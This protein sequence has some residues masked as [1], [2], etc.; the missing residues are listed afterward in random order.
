[1]T[2]INGRQDPSLTALVVNCTPLLY[3]AGPDERFDRP[4]H[5]R[6]ASSL[7]AV[8]DYLTVIQDDAN[9][10]AW[11]DPTLVH[12]EV[13]PLPAGHEG[14]RLFDDGRGNKRWKLDLEACLFEPAG[15]RLFAFGSGSSPWRERIVSVTNLFSQSPTVTVHEAAAFYAALRAATDFAGSELN[16]EG[17]ILLDQT[18]LRLFQRG[19]GAPHGSLRPV[20]ATAD[21]SWDSLLAY[22]QAPQTPAPFALENITPYNLGMIDGVP[23]TFT[24][25]AL[26]SS[27]VLFSA[28]AEASPDAIQD[29]PVAGSGLGIIGRDGAARWTLLLEEEDRPFIGKVEGVAVTAA[30]NCYVVIDKDDPQI[31]SELCQVELLGS[32]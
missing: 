15:Q 19:N 11:F 27:G 5:V 10:I 18:R 24:D 12:V 6:A 14:K 2:P 29:G 17:A 13:V 20:N 31:P 28:A 21:L 1:M 8:G 4:A 25:A 22:L 7:A 9:F 30:G 32:W 23:L 3:R 26:V 16:I